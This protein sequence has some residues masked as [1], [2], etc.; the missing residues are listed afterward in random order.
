[1]IALVIRNF[2]KNGAY[3]NDFEQ[4]FCPE[5]RGVALADPGPGSENGALWELRG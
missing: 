1:M 5:K 3:N 4:L 2:D